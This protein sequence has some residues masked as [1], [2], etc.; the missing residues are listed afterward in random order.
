[1]RNFFAP[2]FFMPEPDQLD[3]SADRLHHLARLSG[4]HANIGWRCSLFEQ[5]QNKK[6]YMQIVGQ[7]RSSILE[8]KLKVGDKLPA[9]RILAE[10]FGTSRASIREALSAMEMLGLVEARSGY[11]N[12]IKADAHE[13]SLDGEML[14]EL[15]KDHSPY[16]IFE[17]RLELEPGLAAMAAERS[18]KEEKS[19]L[20]AI[21]SKLSLLSKA[22]REG[23]EKQEEIE[24]YMEEDRKLHVLIARAAHNTVLYAMFSGV[25]L[26]M[27]EAHWKTIK[28][29][30]ISREGNLSKYNKNHTV[31]VTAICTG[32]AG[33]ARKEMRNHIMALKKDLF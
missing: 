10:E 7:I 12:F 31:I 33:I 25:S 13:S 6:Y 4:C 19:A 23:M 20:K 2:F 22:L 26:M 21:L 8:G 16:E 1:L 30:G 18:T 5:V 27:K 14:K 3:I 11:G 15:I 29:K 28:T 24:A 32:D 17:S 9:E